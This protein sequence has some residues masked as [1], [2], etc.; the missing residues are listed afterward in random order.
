MSSVI[1]FGATS[2]VGQMVT[3]HL[4][5]DGHDV[6]AVTRRPASAKIVL[7]P[8]GHRVRIASNEDAS[9]GAIPA[10]A[11]VNFAY[12]KDAQPQHIYAS[13]KA[14][15]DA[16][17]SAVRRSGADRLIHISTLTVVD[18]KGEYGDA[19]RARWRP[20][21]AYTEA[22]VH[23]EHLL[24]KAAGRGRYSL[25]V[26]RLGNVLGPA[27]PLWV[28]GLAQRILEGRPTMPARPGFS[29][30]TYVRNVAAY[31]ARLIAV[32]T[33]E[34]QSFGRYHHLGELGEHSWA[35]ILDVLAEGVGRGCVAFPRAATRK[36][37]LKGTA[38]GA[39]RSAY[40]R[41]LGSYARLA[42]LGLGRLKVTERVLLRGREV[43]AS[44]DADPSPP[45]LP[46]EEEG[47]RKLFSAASLFRS[48]MLHGWVPPVG[49]DAAMGEL[50]DWVAHT[51]YSLDRS[52]EIELPD[53]GFAPSA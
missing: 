46:P 51:G 7:L 4:V 48:H 16:V 35:E 38:A 15:M 43:I 22:K 39:L 10:D 34:L 11:V 28:A 30:T 1:V 49:F 50:R 12:V 19:D 33:A 23:A 18:V 45:D 29:N 37:G 32:P 2:Y 17:D 5:A 3:G 24:E 21:G 25:A 26:A 42:L 9:A 41:R 6:T 20:A 40:D 36:G 31:V 44:S 14:L 52:G 53:W 47:L 8:F 27:S 13:N